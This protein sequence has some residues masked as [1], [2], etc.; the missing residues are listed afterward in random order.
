MKSKNIWEVNPILRE[1]AKFGEGTIFS[2]FNKVWITGVVEQE[3]KFSH[4]ILGESFYE[5]KVRVKRLSGTE[6]HIP[7]VISDTRRKRL[8]GSLKGKKVE[9]GGKFRSYNE[10]S[11]EGKLHVKLFL[12]VSVLNVHKTDESLVD[13]LDENMIYLKGNLCKAP[14]YRVSALSGTPLT[15]IMVAV[16]RNYS[17]SDYLPCIAWKNM[18]LKARDLETGDGIELYGRVQ[19]RMY[20]KR[21]SPESEEGEYRETYEVSILRLKRVEEDWK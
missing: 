6:D 12:F 18:A 3:F 10:L 17:K 8:R 9:V 20:F 14:S 1:E 19:S 16:D 15:E 21:F 2:D 7:V 4:Q 5:T 11:Q 13:E